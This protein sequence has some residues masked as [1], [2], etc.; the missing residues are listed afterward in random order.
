MPQDHPLRPLRPMTDAALESMSKRFDQMYAK[1]RRPSIAPERLMRALLLQALYSI[2]SERAFCER[3][4][5][6]L[7]FKWFL[8]LPIDARA[9][10]ATTFTKHRDRL[11]DHETADRF[12]V[13][14]VGQA[15]VRRRGEGG[16]P[17]GGSG[18]TSGPLVGIVL[19]SGC[20][21][22]RGAKAPRSL[23]A[24][25]AGARARP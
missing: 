9:F 3:L 24:N 15:E 11:F 8:D 1:A 17:P 14:V 22:T 13:A 5:Y 2:R 16:Q 18:A 21:R 10:D 20:W 6:D 4:N 25:T 19:V 23:N 7:L 12:F